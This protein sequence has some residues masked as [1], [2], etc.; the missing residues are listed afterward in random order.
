MILSLENKKFDTDHPESVFV[1]GDCMKFLPLFPDHFFP[2]A[3]VDPPYGINADTFNN[4]AGLK[5][6]AEGSTAR[7]LRKG[8]L[9]Q[10]S[11]KLKDRSLQNMSCDWDFEIPPPEYF[12]ELRRV[13]RNQI[14]WGGNY[15]DLPP[16]RGIVCWD[17][18][19][20][21]ENFS[22]FELAWTSFDKPA[23]IFRFCNAGGVTGEKKIHPTQKPVALYKWLINKYAAPGDIILDTHVGSASSLVAYRETNHKYV[24]FEI[25]E[26]YYQEALKRVEAAENQMTIYDFMERK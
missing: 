21:W 10:G 23:A 19:Q 26:M 2:L 14:I 25:D 3:I 9:N 11:G 8:R 15:F 12:S 1:N 20:P 6:H 7:R 5:D 24:G 13:S 22:A 16:T 18:E 4:G 17:K